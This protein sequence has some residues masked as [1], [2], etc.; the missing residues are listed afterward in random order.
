MHA[1]KMNNVLA[2]RYQEAIALIENYL[3]NWAEEAED[4]DAGSHAASEARSDDHAAAIQTVEN[5]LLVRHAAS[6]P[7]A[8]PHGPLLS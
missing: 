7:C 2:V 8:Q 5:A 1:R 3:L 4:L 6:P